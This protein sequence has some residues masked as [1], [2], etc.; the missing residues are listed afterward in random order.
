MQLRPTT[1]LSFG[2]PKVGTHLMLENQA[3]GLD[4]PL[5]ALVWKDDRGR[6]WIGYPR[7]DVL[8]DRY[9][10]K[11]PQTIKAM[12]GFMNQLVSKAANVYTY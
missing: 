2:N 11:D 4:L 1:A 12:T 5:R 6:T 10:I 9:G 8:A 7:L 3:V